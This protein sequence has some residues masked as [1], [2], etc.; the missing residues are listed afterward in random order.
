MTPKWSEFSSSNHRELSSLENGECK[1]A[2]IETIPLFTSS[3]G[4]PTANR[5]C[6]LSSQKK[7]GTVY[8][9]RKTDKDSDSL[10]AYEEAKESVTHSCTT[11]K[12]FSSSLKPDVPSQTMVLSSKADTTD[13]IVDNE[14]HAGV[15][16]EQGYIC[17][18][19]TEK[20]DVA[21]CSSSNIGLTE[22][23]T[24]LESPRDICIAI[25]KKGLKTGSRT[26][27]TTEE[28]TDSDAN[29]LLAC[30]SCGG[31]EHLLKMLMCDSCE[32]AFHLSCCISAIEEL[33]ADEWFCKTCSLMKPKSLYGKLSE[34]KVKPSGNTNG[35]PQGMSHIEF[36]LKDTEQYVSGARI[37]RD[38]QAD[39]PEWSGPI[40]R[41]LRMQLHY[42]QYNNNN[43]VF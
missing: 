30:N 20:K 24:E 26:R 25:L 35:R 41:C 1:S 31:V 19:S 39:V 11:S 7:D 12:D 21:E 16:S 34:G 9:R 40:S 33:P 23:I 38:F 10:A 17:M 3:F 29:P 15:P 18:V 4:L 27:L 37:S 6:S 22:P 36:M 43:Q 13:P 8:K 2:I 42:F 32:A 28:L 14:E 5:M